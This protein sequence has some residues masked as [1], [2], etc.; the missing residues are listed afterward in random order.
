MEDL[1]DTVGAL[2]SGRYENDFEKLPRDEEEVNYSAA[3]LLA[4]SGSP[5]GDAKTESAT[6]GEEVP[7][8]TSKSQ[9]NV[10]ETSVVKPQPAASDV[11]G[12]EGGVCTS[13]ESS[14]T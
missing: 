11:G 5:G 13:C 1:G 9:L 4:G 2:D 7:P 10:D 14:H 12:A 8:P 6:I 3:E